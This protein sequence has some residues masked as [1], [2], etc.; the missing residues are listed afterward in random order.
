MKLHTIHKSGN[1]TIYSASAGITMERP[2]VEGGIKA[3]FPSPAGDFIEASID[4]NIEL[5]KNPA[6]TFFSR[7]NG[8]SMED[9]GINDGDLLV[10]DKSLNPIDGKTAVCFLDGDFT[11]KRIKIEKDFC[12]LMPANK[13]YKPIKVTAENDFAIWGI[14]TYVIKKL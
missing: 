3:G 1:L 12:W 10:I 9:M 4:L 7:V 5:L 13:K 2:F 6:A 8:D 14:V 11:L